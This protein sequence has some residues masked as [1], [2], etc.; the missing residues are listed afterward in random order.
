MKILVFGGLGFMGASFVNWA[1]NHKPDAQIK[2]ADAMTYAADKNRLRSEFA[3]EVR[4]VNLNNPEAY[5]DLV[6]WADVAVNFAAETHNDNSLIAPEVFVE[7]NIKGVF[8][9]IQVCLQQETPILHISTDEVFG[10]FPLKSNTLATESSPMRPSSPYSAS[11]AAGDLLVMAWARSY[12]LRAIVTHSTNNF[13]SHQH[14]EKLIPNVVSRIQS[15]SPIELYGS[16]EN[17][18]DWIHVDDH[19]S[20][21][22]CLLENGTWGESYNISANNE[23]SNLSVVVRIKSEM[24][25]PNHPVI[26]VPDRLGHDLRYGLDS[27]KLRKLG[28][29]PTSTA[30]APFVFH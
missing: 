1:I 9:L 26:F 8:C 16:G 17:I 30:T 18:R 21:I 22:F 5:R 4:E 11:K 6:A 7:T 19:S 13:G 12:G 15:G 25:V 20:A 2:I 23:L 10:D 29:R 14:R 24:N 3:G 27:S 28:W